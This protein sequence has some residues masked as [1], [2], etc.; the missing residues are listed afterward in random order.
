VGVSGGLSS[1]ELLRCSM[2]AVVVALS[3][4][5]ADPN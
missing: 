1:S 2:V 4:N 5:F 3:Y